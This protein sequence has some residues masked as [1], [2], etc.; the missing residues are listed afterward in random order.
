MSDDWRVL[1][2]RTTT[3]EIVGDIRISDVPERVPDSDFTLHDQDLVRITVQEVGALTNRV[4]SD[5]SALSWIAG[6]IDRPHSR[7]RTR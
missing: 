4:T 2:A 5:R 3:G 6:T 1:V 7:K